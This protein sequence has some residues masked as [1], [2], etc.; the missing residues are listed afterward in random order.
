[1]TKPDE[2][3][4]LQARDAKKGWEGPIRTLVV[5][6]AGKG[7]TSFMLTHPNVFVFDFDH[8]LQAG[9]P[10]HIAKRGASY[11]FVQPKNW[12]EVNL[13]TLR[14]ARCINQREPMKHPET[15]EP[16]IPETIGIDTITEGYPKLVDNCLSIS[17]QQIMGKG[18]PLMMS[19][20]IQLQTQEER[21]AVMTQSD[22]G[23]AGKRMLDWIREL[24]K[25]NVNLCV[26]AHEEIKERPESTVKSV[27]A[28]TTLP[29]MLKAQLPGLFDVYCRMNRI[30]ANAPTMT[31]V[32]DDHFPL[33]DRTGRLAIIEEAD[34][35]VWKKKVYAK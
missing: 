31:T 9:V 18:K 15:G 17:G 24:V 20:I 34:F 1:M 28:G 3:D 16:F 4:G 35:E 11:V 14:L 29:G 32:P 27:V 26:T 22:F 6:L 5:A 7:K 13:W 10:S 33:K 12:I 2:Y 23:F 21:R 19:D 30:G 8:T 25:W